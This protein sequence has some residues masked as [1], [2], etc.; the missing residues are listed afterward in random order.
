MQSSTA[1]L[2][3][4]EEVINILQP[5]GRIPSLK[6]GVV[7]LPALARAR[8]SYDRQRDHI[9][10]PPLLSGSRGRNGRVVCQKKKKKEEETER[11]DRGEKRRV[12]HTSSATE[13]PVTTAQ[14]KINK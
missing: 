5:K 3:L 9:L 2:V 14:I 7:P 6:G 11:T 10:P 8:K 13:M 4:G 12:C 1:C